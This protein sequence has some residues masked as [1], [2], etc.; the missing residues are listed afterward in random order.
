VIHPLVKLGLIQGLVSVMMEDIVELD[1]CAV[2]GSHDILRSGVDLGDLITKPSRGMFEIKK[3][4]FIRQQLGAGR[5]IL[6]NFQGRYFLEFCQIVLFSFPE[7][8]GLLG[9]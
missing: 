5:L 1:P 9:L 3:T 2:F 6:G 7:I 4:F 8:Y